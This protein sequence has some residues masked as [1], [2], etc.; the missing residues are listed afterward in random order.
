MADVKP[1]DGNAERLKR[2]WLTEGLSRWATKPHPWTALT[3]ELTKKTGNPEMS[4]RLATDL[5]KAHFGYGP[6]A[7]VHRVAHGKPPRGKV[8]G[9]G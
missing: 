7:D 6:G 2:W 1:G 9:P 4:K 3:R 8:I 5:F